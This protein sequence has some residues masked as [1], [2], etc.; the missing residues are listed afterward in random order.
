MTEAEHRSVAIVDDDPAVLESF[1]FLLD[2]MGHTAQTFASAADFLQADLRPLDCLILDHHMP[3]MT[4]LELAE[5]LRRRGADIPIL[6]ITTSPSP[7]IVARAA[8]LG[9]KALEKPPSEKDIF[10][11]IQAAPLTNP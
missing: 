8:V 1:R 5:N 9:C 4:G 11:F 6:L 2:A 10:A 3:Q 7:A